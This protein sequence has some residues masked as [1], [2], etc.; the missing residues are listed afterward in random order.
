GHNVRNTSE[1]HLIVS[2]EYKAEDNNIVQYS[3]GGNPVTPNIHPRPSQLGRSMDPSNP[4]ESSNGS[5]TKTIGFYNTYTLI[6]PLS[7]NESSSLSYEVVQTEGWSLT[8]PICGKCFTEY[9]A[10]FRHKQDH[11]SII[12]QCGKCFTQKG[13]L[14]AHQ[15]THIRERPYSCLECGKSFT[16]KRTLLTHQKIHMRYLFE[17]KIKTWWDIVTFEQYLTA[18]LIPRRLRWEVPPN[19]G[20]MD[21]YSMKEWGDFFTS[22]GLELI[23]FLLSRKRR[24]MILL[25]TQIAELKSSIESHKE[26]EEF[27]RLSAELKNKLIKWDHETQNKKKKKYI[28]DADDFGKGIIYK[29]QT[30]SGDTSTNPSGFCPTTQEPPQTP[31]YNHQD[32]GIVHYDQF[33]YTSTQT[34]SL[35]NQFKTVHNK[36]GKNKKGRGTRRDVY[37]SPF[38]QYPWNPPRIN[39]D[40]YYHQDSHHQGN[41]RNWGPNDNRSNNHYFT[42]SSTPHIRGRE[43][44][45]Y[46][47]PVHTQ[48]RFAPL[49][50]SGP[51]RGDFHRTQRGSGREAPSIPPNPGGGRNVA[52]PSTNL[53]NGLRKRKLLEEGEEAGE[54]K[55]VK[56]Q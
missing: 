42:N 3:P 48:N 18:K 13:N 10:L 12:K 27:L 36:R 1:E 53:E 6:V 46:G 34:P 32:E 41:D 45:S 56:P 25:E 47:H 2:P 11:M 9:R 26:S 21:D 17:K 23:D 49:Q 54:L 22:K 5:H 52:P 38:R 24:K 37:E 55:R 39:D 4:E 50:S 35:S 15:K 20:L 33:D 14:L 51:R 28:R 16:K 31:L 19:D 8:C 44:Q 30:K 29:W 43:F 40:A 7:S